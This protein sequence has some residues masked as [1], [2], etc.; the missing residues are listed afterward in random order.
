MAKHTAIDLFCGCGGTTQG[1]KNAGFR[2]LAAIDEDPLSVKTYRKNHKSVKVWD[3]NIRNIKAKEIMDH[4]KLKPGDLDLLAG[5]PPC[6]A[7]SSICSLN[8]H[9]R[10]YDKK[11]KD[12][13]F[14][15]LRFVKQLHPKVILIENVPNFTNDYR[16]NQVRKVLRELGYKG[17]PQIFNAADYGVPQ[18]RRRML[19]IGNRIGIIEYATT[20]GCNE[21]YRVQDAIGHLSPPGNTGDALHDFPEN[22]SEKVRQLI[23][24]IPKNGGSRHALGTCN[25]LKCHRGNDGFNDVY[26]RMSWD[27]VAPTITGGCV[28]PSKGRFL[29][30]TQN[31]AITLREAALLQSFP[32]DYCFSLERGKYA[33]ALMIGNAFPPNFAE[34]HATKIIQHLEKQKEQDQYLK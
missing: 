2:L 6:Q 9:R 34:K 25:Q 8:G 5:C 18:R 20:S 29:H 3:T 23:A 16:F 32:A 27:N 14:E 28:N 15:Y 30:P 31:R 7:F 13:I 4:C 21:R 11:S 17:N 26:G 10:I 12:L 19:F 22:R 24:N 33:T 1:L